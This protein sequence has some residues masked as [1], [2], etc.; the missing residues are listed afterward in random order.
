MERFESNIDI[1]DKEIQ[2]YNC[3]AETI[4]N[5]PA[6]ENVEKIEIYKDSGFETRPVDLSRYKNASLSM[7]NN[8]DVINP[9]QKFHG[10]EICICDLRYLPKT[11]DVN[12]IEIYKCCNKDNDDLTFIEH[13]RC[14]YFNNNWPIVM[15]PITFSLEESNNGI[16]VVVD[17]LTKIRSYSNVRLFGEEEHFSKIN[18][19]LYDHNYGKHHY[20]Q[21]NI[22]ELDSDDIADKH[23][24][25]L[26][27]T[28][29]RVEKYNLDCHTLKI[30]SLTQ[31]KKFPNCDVTVSLLNTV[32]KLNVINSS[33]IFTIERLVYSPKLIKSLRQLNNHISINAGVFNYLINS[34][35]E[36]LIQ[37][38]CPYLPLVLTNTVEEY[39]T[40]E[41][42]DCKI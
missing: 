38:C 29:G 17:R 10:D 30:Y 18:I 16:I 9:P 1:S 31:L 6:A 14:Y 41:I 3:K 4:E 35:N 11:V 8:V 32:P 25:I 20:R 28:T 39:I 15:R 13:F 2:F 33:I 22:Y 37:L 5:H 12:T 34:C 23:C 24:D 40:G 27:V 19:T 26:N 42:F 7:S 36:T 21:I